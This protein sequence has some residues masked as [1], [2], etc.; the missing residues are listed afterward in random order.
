MP[1]AEDGAPEKIGR[2]RSYVAKGK[3]SPKL[4]GIFQPPLA[5]PNPCSFIQS[6]KFVHLVY[7][8][9]GTQWEGKNPS[10][11]QRQKNNFFR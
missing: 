9:F 10:L 6:M 5:F 1:K 8:S 3:S 7:S 4:A 2:R 11:D